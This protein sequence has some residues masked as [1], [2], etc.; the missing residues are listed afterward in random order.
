MGSLASGA[1]MT[2]AAYD[3]GFSSSAHFSHQF[4]RMFGL[5]PSALMTLKPEIRGEQ[6]RV[7]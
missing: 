5:A 6:P 1:N 7:D 3:A 2:E 4:R